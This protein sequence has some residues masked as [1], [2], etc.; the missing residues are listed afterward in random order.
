[1]ALLLPLAVLAPHVLPL[2]RA[3]PA[4]AASVWFLALALR[5]TIAIGAAVF[6]FV[7]L[8]QT[9]LLHAVSHLCHH[10]VLPLLATHLGLSGHA[11][12]DFAVVLPA[13]TLAASLLWLVCGLAR[14]AVA[15]HVFLRRDARGPGPGG[16]TIVDDTDVVVAVTGWGRARILVSQVAL[17]ALDEHELDASLAHE[18]G[19][20]RRRHRPVLLVG[21]ALAAVARPLPGTRAAQRE[22]TFSLERD[23]DAYAVRQTNDPLALASAICKASSARLHSHG[24]AEVRGRG[25]TAA[26]LDY[27]LSVGGRPLARA[28]E[29]CAKALGAALAGLILAL[30][31]SVPAV[32]VAQPPHSATQSHT[33]D[34]CPA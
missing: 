31:V 17:E 28:P 12:A 11:L 29:R 18:R 5:A 13:M 6:V 4:T 2:H 20:L 22:L 30:L 16:S 23:A 1:M 9:D 8:P 24:L 10:A 32:A 26:R 25:R 19:H 7:Y 15:L 14:A 34:R 33:A 3:D 21:G 27:L